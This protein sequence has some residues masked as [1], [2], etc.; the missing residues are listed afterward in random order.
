MNNINNPH[1]NGSY[2]LVGRQAK[3]NK[4]C[5]LNKKQ[6]DMMERRTRVREEKLQ[7]CSK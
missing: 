2:I 7:H 6:S 4:K 5:D 3:S 1:F